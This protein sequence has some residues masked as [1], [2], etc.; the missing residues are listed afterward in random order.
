MKKRTE[1]A[2][3]LMNKDLS[4][5]LKEGERLDD[6]QRNG[7]FIIQDP[8]RF[9]FGMDAVLLSG[10][11]GEHYAGK[12]GRALDLCTGNGIIPLLLSAKT[13]AEYIAGMEIQ[14]EIADMAERSVEMNALSEKIKILECD[15]REAAEYT[16]AAS[17]NMV[18]VNP[19]YF[20]AGHGII[21]PEDTRTLARHEIACTLEDV[22]DAASMALKD[23][24]FFYMVHRPQRLADVICGMRE[25]LLE[26][27]ALK[28]VYPRIDSQPSM[29][30]IEGRKGAGAELAVEP[31]LI[32]YGRDG[33]YTEEMYT[34]YGY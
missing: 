31:P 28:L 17:F 15:I 29:I 20:K 18:T 11:A 21:N 7:L 12:K 5:F 27:K 25:A 22:L 24:G 19:P 10:F 8:K 33:K 4:G 13:D 1:P 34:I 26:P 30:L 23:G 32:I 3:S 14:H 16:E 2:Q 6:L 9:C